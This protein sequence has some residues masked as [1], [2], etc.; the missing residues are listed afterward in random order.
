MARERLAERLR[1][2]SDFKY[3]A[4]KARSRV[5]NER[6]RRGKRERKGGRGRS[7]LEI[8]LCMRR[9]V[10]SVITRINR[11]NLSSHMLG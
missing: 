11:I 7:G 4:L 2:K 6:Q 1:I 9:Q 3:T 8:T 10:H 5:M